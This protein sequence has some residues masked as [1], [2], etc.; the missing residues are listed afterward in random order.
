M[1]DEKVSSS[2]YNASEMQLLGLLHRFS[3][4]GTI[5]GTP[6]LFIA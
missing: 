4:E 5:H 6:V 1:R 3:E 2:S